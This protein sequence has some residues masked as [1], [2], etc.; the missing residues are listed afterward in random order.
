M[1]AKQAKP[2]PSMQRL[3]ELFSYNPFTGEVCR[4]VD[5][6][7]S[8]SGDVVGTVN[9][10]GSL[11][12]RVDYRILYVHRIAWALHYGC[13]PPEI[14]DHINGIPS[15]NRIC[16]MRAAT[17]QQNNWNRGVHRRNKS[18]IKGA[19]WS[20]LEKRW[21]SSVK[22]NGKSIHLGW[23]DTAEEAAAAYRI[24]ARRYYGEFARVA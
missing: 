23:F 8:H 16:N 7:K 20:S 4:K 22:V 18:G 24:A 15:D 12:C 13:E 6:P 3:R 9:S 1:T 5:V 14:I 19:H 10:R 11:I 21:R 17:T 2:L